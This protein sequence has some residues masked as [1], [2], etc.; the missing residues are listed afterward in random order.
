MRT[1][2]IAS[3]LRTTSVALAQPNSEKKATPAR[4]LDD[5]PQQVEAGRLG[6]DRRM[7]PRAA[8][9]AVACRSL[10]HCSKPL[11]FKRKLPIVGFCD[12]I[13]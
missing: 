7:T 12:S 13:V 10:A 8:A 3:L 1:L 2:L 4:S 5:L 11:F 6:T 9:S